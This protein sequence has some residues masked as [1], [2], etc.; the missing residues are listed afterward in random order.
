LDAGGNKSHSRVLRSLL[1]PWLAL[2]ADFRGKYALSQWARKSGNTRQ[3]RKMY[4]VTDAGKRKVK[5]MMTGSGED[6]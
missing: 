4:K 1:Q 5:A 2:S 3:A 6:E